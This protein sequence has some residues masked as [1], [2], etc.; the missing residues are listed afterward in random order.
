M[1]T[2]SVLVGVFAFDIFDTDSD[3]VLSSQ[4]VLKMFT[5]LTGS[6]ITES[7]SENMRK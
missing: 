7:E 6:R 4:Q 1:Y 3:G 5:S 2:V